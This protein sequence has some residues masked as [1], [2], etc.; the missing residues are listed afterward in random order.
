MLSTP[1]YFPAG[2]TELFGYVQNIVAELP[3]PLVLAASAAPA[4][5]DPSPAVEC[6]LLVRNG[7]GLVAGPR[8]VVV[9]AAAER[10]CLQAVQPALTTYVRVVEQAL[11]LL[12]E[13][14]SACA[15]ARRFAWPEVEHT[16][17]PGLLMDMGVGQVLDIPG[18]VLGT[19][20][21]SVVWAYAQVSADNAY[22]VRWVHAG[23]GGLGQLWHAHVPREPVP[24]SPHMVA[25][26][27][28]L[29][30]GEQPALSPKDGLYLRYRR[31]VAGENGAW[32]LACPS[33][34]GNWM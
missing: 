10:A 20:G 21:A 23:E 7:A 31:L 1:Y 28:D 33:T 13:A 34:R 4:E 25:Q 8:L 18:Q 16:L 5:W 27:L 14:Y 30:R 19:H 32:R 6:G 24:V 26:L 17:V 12:R 29:A 2:Q 15:A 11:P 22:G 9:T 3:L